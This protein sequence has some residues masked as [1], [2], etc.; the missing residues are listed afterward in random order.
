M[1]PVLAQQSQNAGSPWLWVGFV[2][3]IAAVMALDLGVFH[4]KSHKV[5]VKEATI[6]VVVWVALALLFNTGIIFWRGIESAGQFLM[7]YVL[8]LCMSVD[9][10][11]VFI[12]IFSYFSVRPEHQ[13]RV[14]FW[15]ILGAVI[16]RL[17]FIFL[18][19]ELAHRFE[20]I[21]YVFGGFLLYTGF[22]LL[23]NEPEV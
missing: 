4:R 9:N 19:V 14:L 20:W 8:E 2:A 1:I 13:H 15:G 5:N 18:G 3:L 12:I 11:F 21:L 22:K 10:I 17:L 6:W 23:F 16:M 7:A